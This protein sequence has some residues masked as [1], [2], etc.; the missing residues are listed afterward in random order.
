MVSFV[1]YDNCQSELNELRSIVKDLAA[2]LSE[3]QWN[4]EQFSQF[5]KIYDYVQLK[6]LMDM[7]LYDVTGQQ[8]LKYLFEI[9]KEYRVSKIMVLADMK[10]SPMEYMK[11]GIKADSLL[12]RPWSRQQAAE[13]L[14]E[15]ILE[16]LK[17][18]EKEKQEGIASYIIESKDGTLSI[19]YEQIYYFEAREKKIFVCTGKEEFG[20]YHTIDKLAE[21]LPERFLR[22]HRGFIVNGDKIRKIMLSQ[23]M[24]YLTD[25]FDVP[26][27]RSYKADLKGFGRV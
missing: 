27:S 17:S 13:V 11:P 10:T 18:I 15:F 25:G 21:E 23:N 1:T 14:Q 7:L 8:A 3:E 20:F 9:R 12:L 16:Y 4:I 22:C 2:K 26:L 6:P 5:E 19:P 24:I